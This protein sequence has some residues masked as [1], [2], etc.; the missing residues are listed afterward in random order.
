[1]IDRSTAVID[2][3]DVY[4][5]GNEK[6]EYPQ[7]WVGYSSLT[8][9]NSKVHD[10]VLGDG[11]YSNGSKIEGEGCEVFKNYFLGLYLVNS[12]VVLNNF[13]VYRNGNQ[14]RNYPQIW[15]G[16][17]SLT[18]RNSKVHDSVN[19]TGIYSIGSKIEGEGCEVFKNYYHGLDLVNSTV[20]LSNFDV[21]QNGNQNRDYPQIWLGDSSLTIRN[22][23]VHDSVNATGIYSVRSKIIRN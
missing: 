8:I 7:I 19:A 15:L 21:Y 11:I 13:D 18:I 1:M 5:N 17:S 23:K 3:F 14:S 16:D 6:K 20:V 22:S 9:K 12:T 10:S 2:Y 4:Q